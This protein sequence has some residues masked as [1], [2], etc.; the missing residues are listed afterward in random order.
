M[1]SPAGAIR[2]GFFL[3][4]RSVGGLGRSV[5]VRSVAGSR[6]LS[7]A[8]RPSSGAVGVGRPGVVEGG[9]VH[10]LVAGVGVGRLRTR[11]WTRTTCPAAGSPPRRPRRSARTGCVR[12]GAR[13]ART[14]RR[15]GGLRGP[16]RRPWNGDRRWVMALPSGGEISGQDNAS[17]SVAVPSRVACAKKTEKTSPYRGTRCRMTSFSVRGGGDAPP[18][19]TGHSRS[20]RLRASFSMMPLQGGPQGPPFSLATRLVTEVALCLCLGRRLR[21]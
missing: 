15:P 4:G 18:T 16:R 9:G 5:D 20:C 13:P 11:R 14:G 2:R 19:W 3:S 7:R 8:G 21:P 6:R 1:K 17:A 12:R 10:S